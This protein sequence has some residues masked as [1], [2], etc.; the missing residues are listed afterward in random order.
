MCLQK[1]MVYFAA[2]V[3]S[4]NTECSCKGQWSILLLLRTLITLNV[5]AKDWSILML[6]A[7]LITPNALA[8]DNGLFKCY[9][10]L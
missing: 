2:T 8:K 5:L 4:D 3:N 10:E 1:T 9:S 6:Q 7:T